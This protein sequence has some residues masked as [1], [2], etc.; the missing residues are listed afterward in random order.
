M[1]KY[2]LIA[3]VFVFGFSICKAYELKTVDGVAVFAKWKLKSNNRVAWTDEERDKLISISSGT[4]TVNDFIS[5]LPDLTD[6]TIIDGMVA[7]NVKKSRTDYIKEIELRKKM[8]PEDLAEYRK[9][10]KWVKN[11]RE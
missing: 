1:K 7:D 5:I 11:N 3:L 6:K 4:I 2:L 10:E 9:I 8:S